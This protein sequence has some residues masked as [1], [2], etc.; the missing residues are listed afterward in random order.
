MK[1]LV[2]ADGSVGEQLAREIVNTDAIIAGLEDY[3]VELLETAKN[4]K[5]I[6]RYRVGY[7]KVDI[8]AAKEKGIDVTITPSANGDSMGDMAVALMLQRQ[9]T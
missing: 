6:S 1:K 8:Q 5:V 9:E 2:A 3:T 4:L 7:D